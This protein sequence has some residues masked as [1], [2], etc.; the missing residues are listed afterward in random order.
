[1]F[2][3]AFRDFRIELHWFSC[4]FH[5]LGSSMMRRKLCKNNEKAKKS[6]EE[7]MKSNEKLT[8]HSISL[9]LS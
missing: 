1:M 7:P 3:L 6:N 5:I 2:S 9:C 8:E 4:V